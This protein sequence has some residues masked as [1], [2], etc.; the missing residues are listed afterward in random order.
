[1]NSQS[2]ENTNWDNFETPP[3][4]SRKGATGKHKEYYVKEGGGFLKVWAMVS[5]VSQR[6]LVACP[7]TES[8]PKCELTNLLVGFM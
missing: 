5:Q 7:S 4:E 1:M 8:V 6:L 2:L 3:W